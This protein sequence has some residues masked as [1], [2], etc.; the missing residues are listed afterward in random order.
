MTAQYDALNRGWV[1]L[2]NHAG[3][4]PRFDGPRWRWVQWKLHH[5][6]H[7]A[8]AMVDGP[9]TNTEGLPNEYPWRAVGVGFRATEEI[10]LRAA[11]RKEDG[12]PVP[13]FVLPNDAW[14]ARRAARDL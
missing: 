14:K 7:P 5:E 10:A 2:D 12:G 1:K 9:W 6:P 8:E 4:Q 3:P 11:M 13:R